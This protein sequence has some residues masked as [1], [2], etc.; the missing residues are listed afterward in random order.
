MTEHGTLNTVIHE[1]FR[2]DF[3]RFDKALGAFPAGSRDRS[4]QLATAWDNT[5]YQL[6]HHHSDEETI[7]WPALRELGADESLVGDLHGEHEQLLTAL[8]SAEGTMATF[9][10]D[11]SAE[12][13][14][15]SRT[16]IAELARVF[17]DHIVHEV[18]DLEPFAIAKLG[19]PPMKA[20]AVAVRKAHK[21]NSG[22][23]F[24]WLHDG[25]G[26]A[27]R[28]FLRQDIP[29]PVMFMIVKLGGRKYT[30]TIAPVWAS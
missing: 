5:A 7:F 18:R 24:A 26:D 4:A 21:G 9:R 28:R 19:T 15:S 12:N 3:A 14:A 22:T 17:E 2:R 16:S 10:A 6:H 13:A 11:P 27:E 20:A 30:K 8:S 23:F 1:A 25:A 29:P